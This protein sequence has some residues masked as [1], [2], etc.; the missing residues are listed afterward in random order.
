MRYVSMH[1]AVDGIQ[2]AILYNVVNA[3]IN[4]CYKTMQS[5]YTFHKIWLAN[6]K[7][8]I[9]EQTTTS[10]RSRTPLHQRMELNRSRMASIEERHICNITTVIRRI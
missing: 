7:D 6:S 1:I 9:G 5:M 2:Q 4:R 3:L 10:A 8:T